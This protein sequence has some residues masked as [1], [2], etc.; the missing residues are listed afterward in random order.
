M[1][2]KTLYL[3]F[4]FI[5]VLHQEVYAGSLYGHFGIGERQY[6]V[7]ARSLGMGGVNLALF[8]EFTLSRWNPAQ[9]S[10][11]S[12]VRI[13]LR[14]LTSYNRVTDGTSST[15][16][17]FNGFSMGIPIGS[18]FTVG[19]SI[20]PISSS[21]YALSQSGST[22]GEAWNLTV[23]GSGGISSFGLGTAYRINER[24]SI[25]IKNDWL[26]GM[27]EEEWVTQFDNSKLLSSKFLKSNS[28]DGT[29]LT[30]G[31]F[32]NLNNFKYAGSITMPIKFIMITKISY[33]TIDPKIS[34]EEEIDYPTELRLGFTYDLDERYNFGLDYQ[35]GDWS[36]FESDFNGK[37]GIAYDIFGGIERKISPRKENFFN[38]LAF[39]SGFTHRRLYTGGLEE[40]FISERA[41]TFG[42]GIPAH[43]GKE[44][45]D[46][47]FSYGLRGG[48]NSST[49][50]ETTFLFMLGFSAGEKW[51]IRRRR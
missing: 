39:R 28:F 9:W 27:K 38:K 44:I 10:N 25:G 21:E 23:S 11:I 7:S 13:N 35:R 45:I 14:S 26:F 31:F 48:E 33:T 43:D 3:S 24:F 8:D 19:G 4:C 32:S 42:I 51:F 5:L 50:E 17:D 36:S 30:I 20:Y 49:A 40:P 2:I 12:P 6:A 29:L 22:N 18:K 16:T 37:F 1:R 41:L 15:F 47:G 34:Q 46:I